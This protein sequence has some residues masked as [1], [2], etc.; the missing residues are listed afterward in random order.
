[1]SAR[2]AIVTATLDYPRAEACIGSWYRHAADA[3]DVYIVGQ[4]AGRGDWEAIAHQKN[5]GTTYGYKS[6]E[7]LGVVP[8]FNVGVQRALEDG[9]AIIACLHD[10]LEIEQ[11]GWDDTVVNLFKACPRAGLCGFGGAKGLGS[12]D[13]YKAPYHPMQLARQGFRSNMRHAEAHGIRSE[14]AEPVACLDGFSQIGKREFWEGYTER[15]MRTGAGHQMLLNDQQ[16]NL[17]AVMEAW[18][19]VHHFYDGMLGCFAKRLGYMGWY[20]PVAC[21]H[22]GGVTAVTDTRYHEWAAKQTPLA[23]D[24]GT[25]APTPGDQVFWTRAHQIGYDQFRDVLPI[26]T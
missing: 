19:V 12:D 13:L 24:A 21:H 6:L 2:L 26:R 17:F 18:G 8:A 1:M 15:T 5:G 22:Y 7:I 11:G 3:I 23:H 25:G 16:T 10:D 4:T 9:A 14:V 20:L